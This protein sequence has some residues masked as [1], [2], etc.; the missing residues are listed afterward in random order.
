MHVSVHSSIYI[1][2]IRINIFLKLFYEPLKLSLYVYNNI[3]N[4]NNTNPNLTLFFLL[5][6]IHLKMKMTQIK[7]LENLAIIILLVCLFGLLI[8]KEFLI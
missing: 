6:L 2:Y 7:M 4:N 5:F 8:P 1:I 3:N